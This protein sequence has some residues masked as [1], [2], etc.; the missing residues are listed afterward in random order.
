M[1]RPTEYTQEKADKICALI[2]EGKTIRFICN[3]EDMPAVETFYRWLRT[4]PEF[5]EQ[6]AHAKQDQADALVEEILDIADMADT[7][8]V[9]VARLRVDT[10]KW[11]ASKMKA[12]KYGDK[13]T[14]QGDEDKPIQHNMKVEFVGSDNTDS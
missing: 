5:Q 4:F 6:Y 1:A 8:D 13:I 2:T 10:R 7:Q 3:E 11:V 12:K 14:H 9:Q